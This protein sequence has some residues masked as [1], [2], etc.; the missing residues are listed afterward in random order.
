MHGVVVG[1][2]FGVSS[3][4]S[5]KNRRFLLGGP[6]EPAKSILSEV[7]RHWGH[8]C[9]EAH[10]RTHSGRL[11]VGGCA[12]RRDGKETANFGVATIR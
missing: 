8:E 2:S 5:A 6:S 4:V 12:G 7:G 11:S 1:G 10:G 3:A 9:L